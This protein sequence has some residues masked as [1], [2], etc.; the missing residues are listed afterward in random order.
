MNEKMVSY[1]VS[2]SNANLYINLLNHIVILIGILSCVLLM[3]NRKKVSYYI[4]QSVVLVLLTSVFANAVYYGNP[5]H[6]VT[7]AF[8]ILSFSFFQWKDKTCELSKK[9]HWD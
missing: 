4:S 8:M 3:N 9:E 2:V 5:F 7:F 1:L 6:I